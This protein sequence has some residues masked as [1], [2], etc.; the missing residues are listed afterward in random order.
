MDVSTDGFSKLLLKSSLLLCT[1]F[2]WLLRGTRKP[3]R[4]VTCSQQGGDQL[5]L[6]MGRAGAP[7]M[8]GL[9]L[10]SL[11]G[12]ELPAVLGLL[13]D[14]GCGTQSCTG[15]RAPGWRCRN[16]GCPCRRPHS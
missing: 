3:P 16:Q 10:G 13:G 15:S 1:S 2:T 7:G 14:P 12:C 8:V 9:P 5:L 11:G 6:Q 4:E